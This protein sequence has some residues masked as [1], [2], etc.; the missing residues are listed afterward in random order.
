MRE[1]ERERWWHLT[2]NS[3]GDGVTQHRAGVD[4]ALVLPGV[5]EGDVF[6]DELPLPPT[7]VLSHC[8]PRV[9]EET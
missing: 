8:Q 2:H 6:D 7:E 5:G 3:Q 1:R 4:L 9:L